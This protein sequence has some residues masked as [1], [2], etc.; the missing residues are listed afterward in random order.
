VTPTEIVSPD[1]GTLLD[2]ELSWNTH[3]AAAW[4]IGICC[5]PT[6][7]EPER[8]DGTELLLTENGTLASP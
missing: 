6:T 4:L 3:G 8:G 5:W 7:I 1:A 2:G